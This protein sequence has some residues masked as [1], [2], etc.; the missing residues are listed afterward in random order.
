[1]PKL[2]EEEP[3]AILYQQLQPKTTS[4]YKTFGDEAQTQQRRCCVLV[5]LPDRLMLAIHLP[6]K[7]M[8]AI[9]PHYY[10]MHGCRYAVMLKCSPLCNLGGHG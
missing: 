7:K 6:L 5:H 1:M 10:K 3:S 4:S 2:H 8:V 9:L